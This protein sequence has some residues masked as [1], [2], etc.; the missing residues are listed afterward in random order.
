MSVSS[1]ESSTSSDQLPDY[2]DGWVS[3]LFVA[4]NASEDEES[5]ICIRP[6][7][8]IAIRT[9]RFL[10]E[11]NLYEYTLHMENDLSFSVFNVHPPH[12]F[13]PVV[14]PTEFADSRSHKWSGGSGS[15]AV[16]D[17]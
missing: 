6:D 17:K 11:K 5:P 16:S 2:F 3:D 10:A 14:L 4:L 8:V 15:D 1:E 7:R 12:D 9:E 13:F